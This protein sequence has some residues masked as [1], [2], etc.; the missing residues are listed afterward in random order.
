VCTCVCVCGLS[1]I[2]LLWKFTAES[3]GEITDF[4]IGERSAKLR[5][6]EEASGLS[7]P[8]SR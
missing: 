4:D 2:T 7:Q 3:A 8:Q 5:A 6:D 1:A